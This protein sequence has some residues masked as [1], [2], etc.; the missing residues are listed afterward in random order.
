MDVGTSRVL[1]MVGGDDFNSSQ[2]N[3][4][5]QARRQPGSAFKP[6]IYAAALQR[7]VT[8]ANL[9]VDEPLKLQGNF[10]GQFWEPENFSGEYYGRT[11]VWTGLVQSRN[12]VAI[13]ILQ[14]VGTDPVIKLAEWMGIT[15]QLTD[16]LSLALGTSGV[17]LIEM[18]SAYNVFADGGIYRKPVFIEKIVDRRGKI[19]ESVAEGHKGR[20]VLSPQDAYLVT[21]MLKGVIATGTGSQ[22]GGLPLEAAGKTGTSDRNLDAWFVGYTP[23]LAAGV[24]IGFDQNIPL[25]VSETGGRT[26]APVWRDFMQR[27]L[28]NRLGGKKKFSVPEGVV[29]LAMDPLTGAIKAGAGKGSVM[30]AFKQE[31]LPP[32]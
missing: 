21:D 1:A 32:Q 9:I 20:R 19:L 10:P 26:A 16:N 31:M 13:K 25:G 27:A 28:R 5:V 17:S 29:F 18:T 23:D 12:V 6:I 30:T 15:G 11:T 24:W 14:L 8:P 3:R 22:A 4:A 2:Y 7:T